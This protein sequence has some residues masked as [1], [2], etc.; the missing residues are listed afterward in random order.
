MIGLIGGMSWASTVEY[1]R[2]ANE[3]VA[4]RLGG[5]HSARI[6][7]ASVDFADAG[8]LLAEQA[9][10]LEAAGADFVLIGANTMHKVAPAVAAAVSIPL[11]HIADAIAQA[12]QRAGVHT[13]GLLGTAYTMEQD[14]ISGP[15]RAA[16]LTVLTPR[17]DDR[18]EVHRVIYGELVKGEVA[19]PSRLFHQQVIARLV[20]RGAQGIVLGCT[21]LELLIG[22]DDSPVPLFPTAR[23]HVEAAVERALAR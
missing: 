13:V 7:V 5:F 22:P 17:A 8:E 19:D 3:L 4:Q 18:V 16:G 6:I 14:F 15:L 23:L 21:E 11:V 10:A 1:Y 20:E 9:R 12:A 2:L